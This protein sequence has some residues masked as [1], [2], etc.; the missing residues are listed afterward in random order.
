MP[1]TTGPAL[2]MMYAGAKELMRNKAEVSRV[3]DCTTEDDILGLEEV[4]KTL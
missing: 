2:R 4:L 1:V 3:L